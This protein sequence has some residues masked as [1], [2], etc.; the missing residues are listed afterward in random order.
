MGFDNNDKVKLFGW[1]IVSGRE[2]LPWQR[3][4]IRCQ[5]FFGRKIEQKNI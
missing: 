3:T 2:D 4:F 1:E 5:M